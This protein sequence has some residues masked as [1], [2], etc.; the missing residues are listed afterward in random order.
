MPVPGPEP[1]TVT[2]NPPGNA[3]RAVGDEELKLTTDAVTGPFAA[4]APVAVR[5]VV[6]AG[7]ERPAPP[8]V[9][10]LLSSTSGLDRLITVATWPPATVPRTLTVPSTP[11]WVWVR[12]PLLSVVN[13]TNWMSAA[14]P[15]AEL[16]ETFA[17]V[18]R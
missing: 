1:P 15:D 2:A 16:M 3:C 8:T 12:L 14:C 5:S 10:P 7:I 4:A 6:P 17:L 9:L 13:A 18:V 11:G